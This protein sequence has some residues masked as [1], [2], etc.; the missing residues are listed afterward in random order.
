MHGAPS[1]S[2]EF[3]LTTYFCFFFVYTCLSYIGYLFICFCVDE[4]YT[5]KQ[6]YCATMIIISFITIRHFIYPTDVLKQWENIIYVLVHLHVKTFSEMRVFPAPKEISTPLQNLPFHM[7]S[8][9][10]C[11]NCIQKPH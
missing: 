7:Y 9:R 5:N 6:T 1:S 3:R 10:R 4:K 11:S 2:R 8:Y